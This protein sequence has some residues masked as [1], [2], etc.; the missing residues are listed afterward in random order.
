[1]HAGDYVALLDRDSRWIYASPSYS[2]FRDQVQPGVDYCQIVH[3][4]DWD[5]VRSACNQLIAGAGNSRLQYR[6]VCPG[7]GDRH[8]ESEISL[9]PDTSRQVAQIV[10][11]SRDITERKEMEAYLLH[12]S[13]HD[14][15]T[16]LPNRLLL[17][18]RM[19][20][21]T[22]HLGRQQAPVGVL[23]IDLDRF[24]DVNDTLGHAAG[25]RLL[26]VVAE[27]LT[28]SVRE[29]DTV[30]RLSGDEFV[31]LLAGIQNAQ[32]AALIAEKILQNVGEPCQI[33]G[34]ELHMS[35]SIG[36]AIFPEDG[37]DMDE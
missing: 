23:F 18:D 20:Q 21:A 3:D 1:Q 33:G 17:E 14:A 34:R 10:L 28:Q 13:Y 26:Q 12:Q 9:V 16:G 8:F 30:A 35:P 4:D 29:G 24:K 7:K 25:D 11:V 19:R 37:S 22:A 6:V 32:D 27:R 2:D 36:I 31:V 15:L 5:Q